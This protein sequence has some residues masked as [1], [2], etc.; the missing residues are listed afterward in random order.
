[1]LSQEFQTHRRAVMVLTGLSLA[2]HSF[3]QG[4]I[5]LLEAMNCHGSATPFY[6]AGLIWNLQKIGYWENKCF[7]SKILNKVLDT[8]A[9]KWRNVQPTENCC[10]DPSTKTFG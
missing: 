4:N 3:S 2:G 10:R 5:A 6:I 1:M 9:Q 8:E 7:N